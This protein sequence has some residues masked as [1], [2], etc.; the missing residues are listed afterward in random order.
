MLPQNRLALVTTAIILTAC[1]TAQ[2]NPHYQYSTKY[3]GPA[4]THSNASTTS[5]ASN[6]AVHSAAT[7]PAGT[8]LARYVHDDP[9]QPLGDV[10]G[11]LAVYGTE[12]SGALTARR[13]TSLP[14][15]PAQNYS[16]AAYG[17]THYNA[18]SYSRVE[19]ICVQQGTQNTVACPSTPMPIATQTA[20]VASPYASGG[21]TLYVTSNT[22]TALSPSPTESVMP[23]SYGTPGYEAMKNA[24]TDW[25]ASPQ[26]AAA[27]AVGVSVPITRPFASP[28]PAPSVR[29][30]LSPDMMPRNEQS[31]AL[32]TQHQIVTGDTVYSFARKLCSSVEEIKA[33]NSLDGTFNIRLGDTIRLP[34]SKC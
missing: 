25:P 12:T 14:Q 32:G 19:A 31:Y 16:S 20:S 13:V 21:Q 27:A 26:D 33:I 11:S 15:P 22:T 10:P 9:N 29:Q 4:S 23:D 7:A 6:T 18:P 30:A 3:N 34:A 28:L 2:E 1:A 8:V 17:S 24:E 5:H